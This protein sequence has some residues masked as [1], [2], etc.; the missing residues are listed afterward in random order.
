MIRPNRWCALLTGAA[1]LLSATTVPAAM[2]ATPEFVKGET[3]PMTIAL[4]PPVASVVKAKVVKTEEMIEE[5]TEFGAMFGAA[6]EGVI[7]AGGYEVRRVT[8]EEVNAD[9]RL[10]EYVVD[11]NRR[12]EELSTQ[13]RPN[14]IKKRLYNAG[15][16]ARLLAD[17]LNVDAI[18]FSR[19]QVV[20][21]TGGRTA[22][23]LLVGLGT[24]G[25]TSA[26]L[27]MVDGDTADVEALFISTYVGASAKA[28]EENPEAEIAAVAASTMAKLP[29]AGAA[30]AAR[31]GEDEDE[32]VVSDVE[33]LL[34]EN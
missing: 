17:Y 16:E 25:A 6:L 10:Q 31:E 20:A 21:A 14:K 29:A 18:A 1:I 9:P 2:K 23:A 4:L 7:R 13:V 3:R 19:L 34:E 27:M 11:A 28:I 30:A 8:P 26:S 15:D 5:S 32:D 22:V 24:L 12:Y 33:S